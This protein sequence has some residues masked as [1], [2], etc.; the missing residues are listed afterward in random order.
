MADALACLPSPFLPGCRPAVSG[1]IVSGVERKKQI[2]YIAFL[3]GSLRR[4]KIK[5]DQGTGSLKM[6]KKSGF[7]ASI[8]RRNEFCGLTVCSPAVAG[9]VSG[10]SDAQ[11]SKSAA[12]GISRRRISPLVA[13]PA[14]APSDKRIALALGSPRD[15]SAKVISRRILRGRPLRDRPPDS[16]RGDGSS[17]LVARG[18]RL[19]TDHE[20]ETSKVPEDLRMDSDS[21]RFQRKVGFARDSQGKTPASSNPRN[22]AIRPGLVSA[23]PKR[24]TAPGTSITPSPE[25]LQQSSITSDTLVTVPVL[26]PPYIAK[27]LPA[28]CSTCLVR[29]LRSS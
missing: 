11:T 16:G 12:A 14:S 27:E 17:I 26:H 1:S 7:P 29:S 19:A 15:P 24:G 28:S 13:Q 8:L 6:E 22:Y 4:D 2:Q 10:S 23:I 18:G 21:G 3:P 9:G 25:F 5:P 20:V